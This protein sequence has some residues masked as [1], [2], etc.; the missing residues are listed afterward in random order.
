MPHDMR[1]NRIGIEAGRLHGGTKWL[2]HTV[3]MS[4]GAVAPRRGENPALAVVTHLA[5]ACEHVGKLRRDRLLALASL[6]VG[7]E[8]S[9]IREIEPVPSCKQNLAVAHSRVQAEGD[10]QP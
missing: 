2:V 5:L 7:N 3:A 4:R 1:R 6:R 9:A 8:K 10:E